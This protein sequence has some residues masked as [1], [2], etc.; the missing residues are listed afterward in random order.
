MS[1]IRYEDEFTQQD[2]QT[3]TTKQ[4]DQLGGTFN[5]N[6]I[7]VQTSQKF[8]QDDIFNGFFSIGGDIGNNINTHIESMKNVLEN[9]YTI[10]SISAGWKYPIIAYAKQVDNVV[11]YYPTVITDDDKRAPQ[12]SSFVSSLVQKDSDIYTVDVMYQENED[13][14]IK[15]ELSKKFPT[16]RDFRLCGTSIV[17][18]AEETYR[19]IA[20]LIKRG[21]DA[22][23]ILASG[24]D[25]NLNTIKNKNF[26]VTYNDIPNGTKN[27]RTG[28]AIRADFRLTLSSNNTNQAV[29]HNSTNKEIAWAYGYIDLV[30]EE[31]IVQ[32]Q[33][34]Q[35][36]ITAKKLR[37][38]VILTDIVGLAA[39]PNYSLM[40][41]LT[42]TTMLSRSMYM[43]YITKNASKYNDLIS[44]VLGENVDLNKLTPTDK[45]TM[46][47]TMV[48]DPLLALD[49]P[50]HGY[51]EEIASMFLEGANSEIKAT[52]TKLTGKAANADMI[53]YIIPMPYVEYFDKTTK[54]TREID[55]AKIAALTK[56][57]SMVLG[58]S[59]ISGDPTSNTDYSVTNLSTL[60]TEVGIDGEIIGCNARCY[61]SAEGIRELMSLSAVNIQ[62]VPLWEAPVEQTGFMTRQGFGHQAFF[63]PTNNFNAN[64]QRGYKSF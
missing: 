55:C 53:N 61:L 34:Y 27:S 38:V 30:P 1:G 36:P 25:L 16:I 47:N 45:A 5:P 63:T 7:K 29:S 64:Q 20:S 15:I 57:I 52:V 58:Y 21:L 40:G 49:V 11:F 4:N 28:M 8:E 44:I 14:E 26:K 9:Q 3:Q 42:G 60:L 51:L 24:K 33:Q 56:N 13:N 46:L 19:D 17:R 39:T 6:D 62:F 22:A 32:Q 23:P 2:S 59:K 18:Y 35:A 10:V 54:D 43:G 12:L 50:N 37:P 41:L 31:V 48:L